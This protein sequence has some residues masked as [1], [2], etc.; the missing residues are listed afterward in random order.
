MEN[1]KI[2]TNS[3]PMHKRHVSL[4]KMEN[5]RDLGGYI[6]QDG[7]AVRWNT[8]F[9]SGSLHKPTSTDLKK[10]AALNFGLVVD[11]R[12]SYEVAHRPDKLPA[13]TRYVNIP[14]EDSSTKVWHENPGETAK[15]LPNLNPADYMIATNRE[16]ASKITEGYRQFFSELLG[17]NGKPVLFHCAAGKDR[18]GFA[19]ASLLMILGVSKEIAMQDYLLTNKYMLDAHWR[20]LFFA[21]LFKGKKFADGIQ[22]FLKADE[23]Y[24]SAAFERL[25]NDY[26]SFDAYVNEGL[27]LSLQDVEHLKNL[28]LE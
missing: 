21:G 22:G 19:S 6:T 25:E 1:I 28:Y 26:G 13:G 8:L 4:R 5:L 3:S 20:D 9:R 27:K 15:N 7:R 12:A 10:L 14:M 18:T 23:K 11:F 17:S 24:L 16:L 2:L